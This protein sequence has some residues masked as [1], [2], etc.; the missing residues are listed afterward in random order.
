MLVEVITDGVPQGDDKRAGPCGC[1]PGLCAAAHF[2]YYGGHRGL[3]LSHAQGRCAQ[4]HLFLGLELQDNA[5]MTR[6]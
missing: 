4:E 6:I 2:Q 1:S 3:L 5:V